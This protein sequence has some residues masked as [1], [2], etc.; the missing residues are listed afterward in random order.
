[1]KKTL[2]SFIDPAN[3]PTKYGGQL[4]FNFGDMPIFDPALEKVLKWE[5]TNTN[6][7][8]GPMYWVHKKGESEIELI[9]RGTVDEKERH[10]AVCTVK[11]TVE[12]AEAIAM[13]GHTAAPAETTTAT[14]NKSLAVPQPE[15]SSV[16]LTA[17]TVPPSPAASTTNLNTVHDPTPTD[18]TT[19]GTEQQVV[20]DGQVVP[21][22][23]PEP[24]S[25]VTANDGMNTLS[26]N[27]KS[28]NIPNG[29]AGPHSTT[30]ANLLDPAVSVDG[31]TKTEEAHAPVL[32]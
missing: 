16:L 18:S 30:T 15:P 3:I 25:F 14:D 26:L 6:F 23:R 9:A 10:E 20:Q 2:E 12:P 21:S 32:G 13:N 24:K 19:Q 7:P 29:A 27:E 8:P 4:D 17:P 22:S 1:V 5:G 28:E 31:V 11:K